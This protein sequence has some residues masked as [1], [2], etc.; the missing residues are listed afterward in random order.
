[1][2]S[3]PWIEILAPAFCAH[4]CPHRTQRLR[5]FADRSVDRHLSIFFPFFSLSLFTRDLRVLACL[6]AS[7]RCVSF[8]F[9][10]VKIFKNSRSRWIQIYHWKM[11]RNGSWKKLVSRKGKKGEKLSYNSRD[12]RGE[13]LESGG[14]SRNR[15]RFPMPPTG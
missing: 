5:V 4:V 1:M 2:L 3:W 14:E 9:Q 12:R 6:T 7:K 10:E 13:I 15:L 8:G 11:F